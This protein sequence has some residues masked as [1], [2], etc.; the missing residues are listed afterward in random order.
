MA[1]D[2]T[3]VWPASTSVQWNEQADAATFQAMAPVDFSSRING[4]LTTR[5][6]DIVLTWIDDHLSQRVALAQLAQLVQLSPYHFCRA[7]KQSVGVPPQRY[8]GGRRME[9]AK[10]LLAERRSVTEV[11]L[12]L[13][14]SDT[15]SF[16]A[17]FHKITG[18]TPTA[19]CRSRSAVPSGMEGAL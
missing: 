13:G 3:K 9:L 8:R 19:Y 17:A 15:S 5:Q 4:G 2:Q 10:R 11:G 6:R 1:R 16:T 14:Y 12:V 18:L 7:F